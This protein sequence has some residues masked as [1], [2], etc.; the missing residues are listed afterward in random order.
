MGNWNGYQTEKS[1]IITFI[2]GLQD[3][4]QEHNFY[5]GFGNDYNEDFHSIVLDGP[6]MLSSYYAVYPC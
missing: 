6:N 3:L 4:N 1:E 5:G 2:N